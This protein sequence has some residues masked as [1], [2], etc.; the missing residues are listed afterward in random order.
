MS[1]DRPRILLCRDESDYKQ[2]LAEGRKM[3]EGKMISGY[4]CRECRKP[5]VVSVY[6]VGVVTHQGGITLCHECGAKLT[7]AL[8]SQDRIDE[9]QYLPNVL[10][11]M[12][13]QGITVADL[14]GR[15][16]KPDK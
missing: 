4:K 14:I 15:K 9:V 16:K 1:D 11:Q 8:G 5:L 6:A 13:N 3:P 2:C 12:A 10:E 7:E